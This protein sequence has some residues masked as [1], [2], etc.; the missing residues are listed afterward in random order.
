MTKSRSGRRRWREERRGRLERAGGV[1]SRLE[2]VGVAGLRLE[3]RGSGVAS[4]RGKKV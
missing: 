3:S 4:M 1:G 2:R